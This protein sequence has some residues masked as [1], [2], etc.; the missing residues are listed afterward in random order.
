MLYKVVYNNSPETAPTENP[1]IAPAEPG[2][3]PSDPSKVQ[4]PRPSV[5][6]GPKAYFH[7]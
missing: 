2:T 1:T 4:N 5:Q 7:L 3:A 6:P